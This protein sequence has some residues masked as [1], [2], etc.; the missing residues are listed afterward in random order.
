[1]FILTGPTC[2]LY[3]WEV[4]NIKAFSEKLRLKNGWKSIFKP[5]L[6]QTSLWKIFCDV[7]G[8]EK[9]DNPPPHPFPEKNFWGGP[10]KEC[11][12]N[13]LISPQQACSKLVNKFWQCCSNNLSTRYLLIGLYCSK[14]VNKLWQCCSNNLSTRYLPHGCGYKT[15]ADRTRTGGRGLADADWRTRTARVSTA[16]INSKRKDI[17]T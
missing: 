6:F 5:P 8:S 1:M 11:S 14:L 2:Q 13:F 4:S 9:N 10:R 15:G 12:S 16:Y 3:M 17:Q 7:G